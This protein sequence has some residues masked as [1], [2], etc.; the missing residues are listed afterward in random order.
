MKDGLQEFGS[1]VRAVKKF[2]LNGFIDRKM[3]KQNKKNKQ[4]FRQNVDVILFHL[5]Y[6]KM[7]IQILLRLDDELGL[8]ARLK[9]ETVW[10]TVKKAGN[11]FIKWKG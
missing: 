1:I 2:G 10:N 5:S 6:V 8:L 7:S 3:D 4:F 9:H 11:G